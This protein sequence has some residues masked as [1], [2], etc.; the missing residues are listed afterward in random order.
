MRQHVTNLGYGVS[1]H[2]NT[3]RNDIRDTIYREED[4]V[5]EKARAEQVKMA[6]TQA[7]NKFQS[8]LVKLAANAKLHEGTLDE[9]TTE[10]WKKVLDD[11]C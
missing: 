2:R 5:K 1:D 8:E 6:Y 9:A 10:D 11:G 4:H 3:S 7:Y